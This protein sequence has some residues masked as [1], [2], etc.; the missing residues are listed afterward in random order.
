MKK[1]IKGNLK[2]N[3]AWAL[4]R[5]SLGFI[6]MW[7]FLDKYFGLGFSTCRDEAGV[8]A[9][10]CEKSVIAGGSAT[11]GFLKFAT[12]GPLAEFYQ[13][14]AGNWFID[15]LFMAALLGL[16]IALLLGIGMRIATISGV[17]LMLMMW[18]STLL[19]EN[20]PIIDE[21][22]VYI[23]ALVGLLLVNDQQQ[24]GIGKWWSQT[25]LVK[26]Y[27]FLR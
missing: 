11:E 7:A 5:L 2:A 4:V 27:P 9:V 21:H 20:N 23:F 8:V 15:L 25:K 18:S 3:Y 17:L 22:I 12:D 6:F 13:S 26:N 16:G 14:L 24:L 10:A 19:P 1:K